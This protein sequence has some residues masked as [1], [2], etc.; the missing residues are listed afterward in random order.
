MNKSKD[1]KSKSSGK[2]KTKRKSVRKS[3]AK[4]KSVRKSKTKRRSV[5]KSKGRSTGK[6]DA[7]KKRIQ[8][9]RKNPAQYARV[10]RM[11]RLPS[12]KVVPARTRN[13]KYIIDIVNISTTPHKRV[14]TKY[15]NKI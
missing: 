1:R 2:S 8:D 9:A 12:G 6:L 4:R 11:E 7:A 5:R 13:G 3:K 14:S 10:I 15:V